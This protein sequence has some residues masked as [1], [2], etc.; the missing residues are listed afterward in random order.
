MHLKAVKP[1]PNM[2]PVMHTK[3]WRRRPPQAC[4]LGQ[5]TGKKPNILIFLLDDVGRMDPGF[6]GGGS[7]SGMRRRKW[8]S[9]PPKA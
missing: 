3:I 1:A 5:K 7:P 8:T 9:L 2:D 4:G 6:N